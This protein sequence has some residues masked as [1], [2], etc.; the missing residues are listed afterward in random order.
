MPRGNAAWCG[1]WRSSARVSPMPVWAPKNPDHRIIPQ[2]MGSG[3]MAYAG[4][5]T[6]TIR[7]CFRA[8]TTQGQWAAGWQQSVAQGRNSFPSCRNWSHR[9]CRRAAHRLICAHRH[10]HIEG[11]ETMHRIEFRIVAGFLAAAIGFSSIGLP[12]GRRQT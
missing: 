10:P 11:E 2:K 4:P 12:A 3:A 7:S 5:V 6:H 8:P 9:R 1:N